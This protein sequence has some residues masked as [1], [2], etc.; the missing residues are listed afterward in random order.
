VEAQT[1]YT[2][3]SDGVNIAFCTQGRGLPLLELPPIPFS[4]GAGPAEIP[5]WQAW[6]EQIARRGMLVMY[7][8][9]GAGLSDRDV[10]DYSLD[11]W[12]RDIEAVVDALRLEQFAL[13]APDSLAVPVAIAYAVRCPERVSHLILWQAHTQVTHV[14]NEPGFATVLELIDKDWT[15]FTEVLVQVMEGFSEP[16]TAHREA[17]AMRE[18][19]TQEGLKAAL[20]AAAQ[21]DV[22]DLLPQV[23]SPTLVLHRRDSRQ[24]LSESMKV[25]SGIPNARLHLVE[26]SAYSWALQHPEAV[27][28]AIDEF[29]CWGSR[30]EPRHAAAR[31]S[32][33]EL[34]V[35][36]LLAGGRSTREIGRELVLTVRTVER[37]IS[38]IYR[39]I[40]AHNRAQATAFALDHG[41][42]GR[43]PEPT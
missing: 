27:L 43:P 7:D 26:G 38:N 30:P 21:V 9:R 19:H 37:H 5:E 8:C 6:D 33:R 31:L 14:M 29:L 34:E 12:M 41:L 24:P 15:L 23:R 28:Q 25:A 2:K 32:P 20:A 13:F 17:A 39:K 22:T 11:G 1:Q 40:G 42:A 35:L 18:L 3:A 36:R 16:E 10:Q 4:H